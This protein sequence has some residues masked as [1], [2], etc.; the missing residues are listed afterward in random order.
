MLLID[1][2]TGLSRGILV[3]STT[4]ELREKWC[5]PEDCCGGSFENSTTNQNQLPPPPVV[6]A[7]I[8]VPAV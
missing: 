1:E 4:D 3:V 5:R 8:T 6:T 7:G 2:E